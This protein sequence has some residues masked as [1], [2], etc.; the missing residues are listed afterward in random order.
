MACAKASTSGN[1]N[2]SSQ[3]PLYAFLK[4]SSSMHTD[5]SKMESILAANHPI[6]DC[7][8]SRLRNMSPFFFYWLK[9]SCLC[10]ELQRPTTEEKYINRVYLFLGTS[11]NLY[12]TFALDCWS[13]AQ[14]QKCYTL[15]LISP[16]SLRTSL[17]PP[18][19]SLPHPS[20]VFPTFSPLHPSTLTPIPLTP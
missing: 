7:C 19:H 15:S 8:S 6:K 2:I 14:K 11:I 16:P 18:S 9:H 3:P 5:I 12:F 17:Q 4:H 10:K 13:S 1:I 20:A